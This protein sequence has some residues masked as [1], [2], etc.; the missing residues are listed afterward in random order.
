[1]FLRKLNTT[2]LIIFIIGLLIDGSYYA[3]THFADDIIKS[4]I[5]E[6]LGGE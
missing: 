6:Q 2:L 1:M 4:S 3:Y 5:T